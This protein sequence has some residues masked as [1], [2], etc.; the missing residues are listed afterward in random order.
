MSYQIPQQLQYQEKIMFGLNFKQLLYGFLFGFIDVLILRKIDSIY[1]KVP[2]IFF[3]SFLAVLFMF[4]KLDN[5]IKNYRKFL[6]NREII[7]EKIKEFLGY[8][9]VESGMIIDSK[10]KKLA[11]LRVQPINFSIKPQEEKEAI[12]FSF[13]K[14]LNSLDFPTQILINTESININSY[15]DSIKKTNKNKDFEELFDK[16][17]EHLHKTI[18][19]DKL[20][21]RVFYIVIPEE[22]D[23]QIQV[24]ICLERLR[25]M[26]MKVSRLGDSGLTKLL[27]K[28]EPELIKN[29]STYLE[30]D[31]TFRRVI[32]ASG[33]PRSVELGFLDKIVSSLSDFNLCLHINPQEIDKTMV[34]LNKE[35]QKQ[36]ADLY[37]LQSKGISNPSLEIQNRDTRQTL[38]E[39]Q[40]GKEK[41]FNISLYVVCKAN[42]L[43]E[44]DLLTRKVESEL[45]SLMII[46]RTPNFR[47]LPGLKSCL[48]LGKDFLKETRNITTEALSA[49]FPFTSQFL[50]VDDGGVWMGNNSNGL[51]VIK[52][53]FKLPNPNGL[54]LAQSGGGK[55][56]FCKLLITR[57]LLNDTKVMV[58]DPQG[59]YRALVS[60][61]KGQ[62]V[63]ISRNSNTIINPL[64]MM[65]HDYIEK[66]LSLIDLMQVMLGKLTETQQAFID[67]AISEAYERKGINEDPR[68]WN[69]KPPILSD[70]LANL[71]KYLRKSTQ[72]EINVI[73]SLINK[74]EIYVSGVFSFM[75]R[76]TNI[77]F[78]KDLVCFDI[79][80]MPKQ[81]KPAVMFMVLDYVYMKMKADLSKKILLI[82]EAWSLLGRTEDASYIFEIVK[83]CRKYNLGLLLINQ[84]VEG[85]LQSNAGKSVLANSA[86]TLLMRQKPAV[87]KDICNAFHLSLAEKQHL[88]TCG[89]GEG[90]L[91]M[92]DDHSKIKIKASKE[93]HKVITTNPTEVA[94]RNRIEQEAKRI[95]EPKKDVR[96]NLDDMLGC[97]NYTKLKKEE[98]DYLFRK[99][100]KISIHTSLFTKKKAKY[101]IRPRKNES[102]KHF[103][104]I[105]DIKNY[106]E[107]KGIE[108]QTFNTRKPDLTFEKESKKWAIEVETGTKIKKDPKMIKTK[109]NYLNK[110]YD[111]WFFVV[112]N[113]ASVSAYRKSGPTIDARYL[114]EK[115]NKIF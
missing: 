111:E 5:L 83:T 29:E 35:L 92:E 27:K 70:I 102:D 12:I 101:L 32:Y 115:L 79:G 75:N 68:T 58:I 76:H 82:D 44:L 113:T 19:S 103:F 22:T 106:L 73:K 47:M 80:N 50:E 88:L 66:R 89:I 71:N 36:K 65:G 3:F 37:S 42:T 2:L 34:S 49:F 62:R 78:E 1:L 86:Y 28:F 74:L 48:P 21:N 41:L 109:I 81:V 60:Y 13:Q 108:V 11:V 16:Y 20:M 55:S 87:I 98:K 18:V 6:F 110:N 4:F 67:K 17:Q 107:K 63:E 95:D 61:F 85:L 100:Y 94:E 40:K 72:M 39:L 77:N 15:V 31:D 99:G 51:P 38:E 46:P 59:E 97:F 112:I 54:V 104:V 8:E 30:I 25:T 24:D 105:H 69:R 90:L 64:D 57:Y 84:E 7:D 43:E 9:K 26:G 33:Y 93:E 91:I 45:N 96:I 14:F 53:I 114:A 56:Y 10:Q 52:D 23:L